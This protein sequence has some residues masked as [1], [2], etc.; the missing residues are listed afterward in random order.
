MRWILVL[1][2]FWSSAAL[3]TTPSDIRTTENFTV[4]K[5]DLE[6][7]V[8]FDV[9]I[10]R[11]DA[12][13]EDVRFTLGAN[14]FLTDIFAPGMEFE[15]AHNNG[16]AAKI[17]PNLKAYWPLGTRW[18]PYIQAGLGYAR[19]GGRNIFDF[20]FGPGINYMLA[21]N[22][23]LG[24]QFR[25]DLGIGSGFTLHEIQFPLLFQVYFGI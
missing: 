22:V 12:K 16:T 5:G 17:F 18:L 1:V 14:Y 24:I 3:A 9:D 23:S 13:G 4:G 25:Y 21:Q 7:D 6:T 10:L 20:G 19:A 2:A 8:G 15:V 11:G